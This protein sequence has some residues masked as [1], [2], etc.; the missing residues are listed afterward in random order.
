MLA[1]TFGQDRHLPVV[2]RELDGIAQE[3]V[4][5][6]LQFS[7]VGFKLG[8][9]ILDLA[10]KL[11]GFRRGLRRHDSCQSSEEVLD[12]DRLEIDFHATRF[13]LCHVE[14][15]VDQLEK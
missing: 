6:L 2:G 9:I 11:D 10:V 14:Q 4:Q 5:D 13:D 8:E 7:R 15:V 3:V 1:G 12:A